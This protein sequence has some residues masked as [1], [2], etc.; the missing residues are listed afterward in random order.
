[1]SLSNDA[2]RSIGITLGGF[3]VA[4]ASICLSIMAS[5]NGGSTIKNE[6]L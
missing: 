1:M 3:L 4:V 6:V 5:D 2:E